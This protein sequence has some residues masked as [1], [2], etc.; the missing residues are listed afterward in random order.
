MYLLSGIEL[1]NRYKIE[2]VLGHG[3]FGITYSALD[4]ILKARPRYLHLLEM[5]V[6]IMH[7]V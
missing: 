5:L 4:K 6:S 2:E 1:N 7:M 3:G